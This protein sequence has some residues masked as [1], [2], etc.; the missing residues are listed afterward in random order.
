MATETAAW[1][2]IAVTTS[3]TP[4]RSAVTRVVWRQPLPDDDRRDAP[5]VT[6]LHT[7]PPFAST[8]VSYVLIWVRSGIC[9]E[10]HALTCCTSYGLL[11]PQRPQPVSANRLQAMRGCHNHALS[12]VTRPA[13]IALLYYVETGLTTCQHRNRPFVATL[14][15]G[16]DNAPPPGIT[17]CPPPVTTPPPGGDNP[18]DDHRQLLPQSSPPPTCTTPRPVLQF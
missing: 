7:L 4:P 1:P 15:P 3:T 16:G 2:A 11:P 5:T 8:G 9:A 6:T 13:Q 14:P 18:G 12:H 17:I 10:H